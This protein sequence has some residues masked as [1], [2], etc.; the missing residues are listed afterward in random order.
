MKER[1]A[2][3]MRQVSYVDVLIVFSGILLALLLRFSL[4]TFESQDYL[5]FFRAWYT[6][7]RKQGFGALGKSFSNYTP[8]WLYMLYGVSIFLPKLATVTA[9]KLPSIICDFICAWYVYR[10]VRLKYEKGPVPIFAFFAILFAPT[11]VLN[12]SAWGQIESIY[13]AALIAFLYYVL[14]KQNWLACIAF[15][16]AFS[17]KLQSIYLAP[18]LVVLLLKKVVSWK[19][20]LV[21]P[22]VYFI[23]IIPA[24]IAGRPLADLL[25]IYIGQVGGYTGLVH[26]APNLYTW[27]PASM[28]DMLYP[29]G[30][31][32]AVSLC[33]IYVVVVLKSHVRL[34]SHLIVQLAFVSALLV[35]YFLPKTHD[36][37]FYPSD[38]FSIVFGF[39]FPG[40]FYIPLAANLISFFIYEPFLFGTDVFPQPVLALA[41]LVV[42]IIVVRH[43]MLTFYKPGPAPIE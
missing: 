43:M 11:V 6:I 25:T 38:V 30:V 3:C 42:I 23:S 9:V 12:S 37:Y 24:W 13:T 19:Q 34:S 28:T 27:L 40:Y 4:R 36:R 10:I 17:V 32:L 15:G 39:F 5:N 7:I 21:I 20:V 1:L 14:K 35:P 41:L 18:L 31:I 26:N 29:A 8:L 2:S 16:I 22:A 33:F